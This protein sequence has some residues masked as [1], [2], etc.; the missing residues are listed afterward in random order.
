MPAAV[1]FQRWSS[2]VLLGKRRVDGDREKRAKAGSQKTR[3]KAG[4]FFGDKSEVSSEAQSS[5]GPW[6][7]LVPPNL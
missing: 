4:H 2:G 7:L 5:V 1:S 6:C 3:H